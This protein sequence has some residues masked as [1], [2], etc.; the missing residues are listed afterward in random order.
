MSTNATTIQTWLK[1]PLKHFCKNNEPWKI[2]YT[3][4]STH[5]NQNETGSVTIFE[6]VFQLRLWFTINFKNAHAK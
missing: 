4:K 2:I 6:T 1:R 5:K 3:Q